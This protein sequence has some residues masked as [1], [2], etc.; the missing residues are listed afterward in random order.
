[1]RSRD[2]GRFEAPADEGTRNERLGCAGEAAGCGR[3]PRQPGRRMKG[4]RTMFRTCVTTLFLLSILVLSLWSCA[5]EKATQ[6]AIGAGTDEDRLE[7]EL[8]AAPEVRELFAIRDELA[9]RAIERGVTAQQIRETGSDP[10]AANAL[11]GLTPDEGRARFARI[12]ELVGAL[13]ERYPLL[14]DMAGR[15]AFFCEACDAEGA[16]AAWEHYS[17]VLPAVLGETGGLASGAP[18]RPPLRCNMQQIVS[19]FAACALRSGG[20]G[21]VY[22]ACSY[23]VFCSSCDGGVADIICP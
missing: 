11:L 22:L 2:G 17:T 4:M 1:M 3:E 20:S 12:D 13:F 8:N 14:A 16:A 23:G 21:V 6:P 9:A 7:S 10:D 19:G 15:D 5:D 18:A